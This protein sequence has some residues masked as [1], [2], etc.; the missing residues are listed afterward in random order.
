M[1]RLK[2]SHAHSTNAENASNR[3]FLRP[4][5]WGLV[6]VVLVGLF[7]AT[8]ASANQLPHSQHDHSHQDAKIANKSHNNS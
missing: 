7:F 6:A 2:S 8:P 3:T 4:R 1:E 5:T